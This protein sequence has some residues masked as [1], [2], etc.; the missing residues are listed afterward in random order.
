MAIKAGLYQ[1]ARK[2]VHDRKEQTVREE[3]TKEYQRL[4]YNSQMLKVD[5]ETLFK[6]KKLKTSLPS[7]HS[8]GGAAMRHHI[9]GILDDYIKSKKYHPTT[10]KEIE[11][12]TRTG[13][14][15][16]FLLQEV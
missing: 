9:L 12:Y 14:W 7:A 15:P 3:I 1:Q 10:L 13:E 6:I 11:N 16:D 5:K 2:N 4:L 8:M